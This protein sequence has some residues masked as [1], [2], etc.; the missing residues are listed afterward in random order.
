MEDLMTKHPGLAP[1]P[2]RIAFGLLTALFFLQYS[3]PLKAN[4]IFFS[5]NLRTNATVLDC[6]SGCTLGSSNTDGDYAQWAAV[7]KTFVVNTATTMQAVTYGYGGGTS[8][9]GAVVPAGGLEP[10]LSLFDSNGDF[11]ASTFSGTTCPTGA[12]TLAGNCF[13]VL[14]DGGLLGPG[15]YEI[16]L[17]A[18]ENMSFAENYGPPLKLA[19]GFTGLGSLGTGENLNY[20]FDVILPSN[21][22]APEPGTVAMFLLG[23]GTLFL[24]RFI[25]SLTGECK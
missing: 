8:K 10:Y 2:G 1:G 11:L 18:F 24:R 25:N 4:T 23:C 15:T 9:T 22:S 13:D 16:A 21:V 14:L 17:T 6:G 7:V 19:D 20:A 3:P 5:G 12:N